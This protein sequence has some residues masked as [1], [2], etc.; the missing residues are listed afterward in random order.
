MCSDYFIRNE[1]S[2][3]AIISQEKWRLKQIKKYYLD[4]RPLFKCSEEIKK[5]RIII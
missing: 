4:G 3:K 2:K 5:I 1:A